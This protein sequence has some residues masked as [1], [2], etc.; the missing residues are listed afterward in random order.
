MSGAAPSIAQEA[1][2]VAGGELPVEPVEVKGYDFNDGVDYSRI[3]KSFSTTGFQATNFALAVNEINRMVCYF[4]VVIDAVYIMIDFSTQLIA[5]KYCIY[6]INSV[7]SSIKFIHCVKIAN[8]V[9]R[10]ILPT[11]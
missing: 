8:H 6:Y 9:I 1:V 3:L 7:C 10:I 11:S 5:P 4:A 2:L